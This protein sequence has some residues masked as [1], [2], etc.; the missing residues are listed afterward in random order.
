M[1]TFQMVIYQCA[2]FHNFPAIGSMGCHR[3]PWRRKNNNKYSCK[4]QLPGPSTEGAEA[5]IVFVPV[6]IIL[7]L[8]LLLP[9]WESMAAHR[10]ACGKVMKF[11]T[12]IEDSPKSHHTKF[13]VLKPIPLAP[14]TV[15]NFTFI[16]LITF[17]PQGQSTKFFFPLIPEL[18]TIRLHPMTSFSVI[19]IWPPF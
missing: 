7:L 15:Q 10:T 5:P 18:M 12:M 11:G 3:L 17:E 8:L 6:L 2:K 9:L 19:K 1:V 13:G 4:Q 16:L 14:P